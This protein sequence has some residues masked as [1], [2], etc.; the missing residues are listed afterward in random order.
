MNSSKSILRYRT[1]KRYAQF[2]RCILF[3][4]GVLFPPAC[5]EYLHF[6][7]ANSDSLQMSRQRFEKFRMIF[8]A[9]QS[10]VQTHI[11]NSLYNNLRKIAKI[12]HPWNIKINFQKFSLFSEKLRSEA[13]SLRRKIMV[14][15]SLS[16]STFGRNLD[17]CF[18]V[19]KHK[20]FFN[21]VV[22]K[23]CSLNFG[24]LNCL[25]KC[26]EVRFF[27]GRFYVKTG[28]SKIYTK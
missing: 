16:Q 10:G 6:V 21:F 27:S 19:E 23:L 28:W 15:A 26:Y 13:I 22:R 20:I 11:A 2:Y 1:S 5:R 17:P 18:N 14:F 24:Y 25:L 12:L 7:E 3:H 9:L 4:K 8:L